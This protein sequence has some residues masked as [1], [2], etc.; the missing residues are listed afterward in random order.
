MPDSQV[1]AAGSL[2]LTDVRFADFGEF[3]ESSDGPEGW[4][5]DRV[6]TLATPW[7]GSL[8]TRLTRGFL[9]LTV[10]GGTLANTGALTADGGADLGV[11]G[12][13]SAYDAATGELKWVFGLDEGERG[14][15]APRRLSERSSHRRP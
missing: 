5:I 11:R 15:A 12:Y 7:F 1:H 14:T 3:S 9:S 8:R 10:N 6:V 13:V 2:R 4:S